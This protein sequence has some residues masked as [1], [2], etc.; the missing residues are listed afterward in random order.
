[1][2]R[3]IYPPL[4]EVVTNA[5]SFTE[6]SKISAIQTAIT[7]AAEA[8]TTSGLVVSINPN[9]AL[10][11]NV[12]SGAARTPRGDYVTSSE[13]SVGLTMADYALDAYNFVVITYNE[14]ETIP[15]PNA[16]DGTTSPTRSTGYSI[17]KVYSAAAFG[18]LPATS[19]NLSVDA[20]D[21][22]SV[23][24]VVQ[25]NGAG[26]P[27]SSPLRI[28]NAPTTRRWATS[29]QPTNVTGVTITRYSQDMPTSFSISTTTNVNPLL[30]LSYDVGTGNMTLR[31]PGDTLFGANVLVS[32]GGNFTVFSNGATH[33][34]TIS[35]VAAA[36][37]AANASDTLEV[38]SVYDPSVPMGF[39]RD[40][41]HR[42][43]VG[44][45]LPTDNNP[46]GT[47]FEDLVGQSLSIPQTLTLGA[48]LL[49][50]AAQGTVARLITAMN[51]FSA[52]TLLWS[53]PITGTSPLRHFRIYVQSGAIEFVYNAE[54]DQTALEWAK[55][56]TAAVA[57]RVHITTVGISTFG[58]A[59]AL[60]ANWPDA[61][62]VASFGVSENSGNSS[63]FTYGQIVAGGLNLA[64]EAGVETPRF[65]A[66][67][68]NLFDKTLIDFSER[69]ST[70]SGTR[71]RTYRGDNGFLPSALYPVQQV[72][73]AVW[74]EGTALWTQ[75]NAAL[76][77]MLFEFSNGGI[78]CYRKNAGAAP[79]VDGA[80]DRALF[81]V[82]NTDDVFTGFDFS[83]GPSRRMFHSIPLGW[84]N[85]VGAGATVTPS[86]PDFTSPI[87]IGNLT[88]PS[89]LGV[90]AAGLTMPFTLPDGAVVPTSASLAT[91]VH[92]ELGTLTVGTYCRAAIVGYNGSA[93]T[94]ASFQTSGSGYSDVNATS[95]N[96]T[97]DAAAGVRTIDTETNQ[98]YLVIVGSAT[99]V[100]TL[101]SA[102]VTY[103]LGAI[104]MP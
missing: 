102:V 55:D 84:A 95:F 39:A 90:S 65:R 18:L 72:S 99:T 82:Y 54:W 35:V 2:D 4:V 31:A 96:L 66:D 51:S 81:Q 14:E 5:L 7:E 58:R 68:S 32:G 20:L 25:A 101:R 16:V 67:Y 86:V 76:P 29:S 77:S 15:M 92:L 83:F 13:G 38:F 75:E 49:A 63:V 61:S 30:N 87:A 24:G 100:L 8:G 27:L 70:P 26:I 73:N 79:W 78:A 52:R 48:G 44:S 97:I 40:E 21:R 45:G 11:V 71:M 47:A 94:I 64:T 3:S 103:D 33:S 19:D 37:P 46:H 74:D 41:L 80:W 59:A 62:W 50:T 1:M 69:D 53:I 98:Y 93:G 104:R 28:T 34:V 36:L 12:S 17:I 9:N 10:T 42:S 89:L 6:S 60:A 22:L 43:L 57:N 23:V 56:D 88:I 91:A 85:A